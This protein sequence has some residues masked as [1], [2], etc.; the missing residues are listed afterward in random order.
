MSGDVLLPRPR[1]FISHQWADKHIADRL[2]QTLGQVADVWLDIRNLAPGRPIKSQIDAALAEMDAMVVL[3]SR[4]SS[5]SEG[6][7]DEI[8][9]ARRSNLLIYPVTLEHDEDGR[10]VPALPRTLKGI[11]GLEMHHYGLT[12]ARLLHEVLKLQLQ[13]LPQQ[14]R[15][16][17]L[18]SESGILMRAIV[19]DVSAL[20]Y[21][22]ATERGRRNYW[23]DKISE[24][25]AA[26]VSDRDLEEAHRHIEI[27]ER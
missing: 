14:V 12:E 4:N 23:V 17:M 1:V 7:R 8:T 6:V 5:R 10:P 16:S 15:E 18:N 3:W 11:L 2:Q 25:M 22:N 27:L 20:K 19:G 13:K 9:T 26:F 24:R 21:C